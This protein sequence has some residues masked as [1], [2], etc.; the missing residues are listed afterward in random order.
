MMRKIYCTGGN[1][2][3]ISLKILRKLCGRDIGTLKIP[4]STEAWRLSWIMTLLMLKSLIRGLILTLYLKLNKNTLFTRELLGLNGMMKAESSQLTWGNTTNLELVL[5][6]N[7]WALL[8][9]VLVNRLIFSIN[10]MKK[11]SY[12]L[13]Q[14]ITTCLVTEASLRM[15]K[16]QVPNTKSP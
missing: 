2:C 3:A 4:T 16:S 7:L 14:W 11:T 5:L 15:I 8:L 10:G 12:L 1:G 9:K 13:S 6:Q